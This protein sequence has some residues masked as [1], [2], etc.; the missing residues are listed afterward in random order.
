MDKLLGEGQQP[1]LRSSS[2]RGSGFCQDIPGSAGLKMLC[3]L[4]MWPRQGY[5]G[6]QTN[7]VLRCWRQNA[8]SKGGL[9]RIGG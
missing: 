9:H 1:T 6:F 2:A 4:L 5:L 3:F 8:F 7:S